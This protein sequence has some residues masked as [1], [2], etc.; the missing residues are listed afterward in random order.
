MRGFAKLTLCGLALSGA[1]AP[2][3]ELGRRDGI[4]TG[5]EIAAPALTNCELAVLSAC[6]TNLGERGRGHG[7]ASPETAL[8]KQGAPVADWAA[9]V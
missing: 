4:I 2:A 5:E 8:R 6:D 1:N 9:W 7:F 3:D